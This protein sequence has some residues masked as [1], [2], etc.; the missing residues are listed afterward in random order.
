MHRVIKHFNLILSWNDY[1]DTNYIL[2]YFLWYKSIVNTTK[3]LHFI[4]LHSNYYF[5]CSFFLSGNSQIL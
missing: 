2:K 4:I 3:V 1:W 5:I